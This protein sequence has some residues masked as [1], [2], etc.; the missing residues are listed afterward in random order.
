MRK[1]L[2]CIAFAAALALLAGGYALA[3]YDVLTV[4]GI[5]IRGS[6]KLT[7]DQVPVSLG[8]D[9][10]EV[11]LRDVVDSLSRI[12]YIGRAAARF[13]IR[14][15]LIVTVTEKSPLC[16]LYNG[17]LW[18]LSAQSEVLPLTQCAQAGS[19]PIVRGGAVQ[20]EPYRELDAPTY[21]VAAD[22]L[23]LLR[24]RYPQLYAEVSEVV[25]DDGQLRLILKP[26]S[27]VVDVGTGDYRRKIDM[28]ELV[29]ANNSNPALN[30]DLRF[31]KLAI[32]KNRAKD[33][34][35]NNG[36]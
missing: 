2:S 36:V 9:L 30:I 21:H 16:Y 28:L 34:K 3:A 5:E 26:G 10:F 29:L 19:L 13:D 4:R 6:E 8:V 22:L 1:H 7:P 17:R 25:I 23:N 20:P 11:D 32:L 15:R 18:G 24:V 27:V 14:G 33:R 31:D 35:V 12:D